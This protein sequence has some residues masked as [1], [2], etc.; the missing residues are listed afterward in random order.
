MAGEESKTSVADIA[1]ML[2]TPAGQADGSLTAEEENSPAEGTISDDT[3]ETDLTTDDAYDDTDAGADDAGDQEQDDGEVSDETTD[4]EEDAGADSEPAIIDIRDDD[5]IDVMIDGKLETKTIGELKKAISLS[6]A[7]EKRLHE[8]TEIR[9]TAMA[10]RTTALETLAAQERIVAAAFSSLE[11]TL[12]KAVIPAPDPKMKA[13]NPAAYL[14]HK[15]AYDED[16]A[17]IA[18]AKKAVQDKVTELATQRQTRLKEYGETAAQQIVAVIPEL[19]NPAKADQMLGKL[20]ATAKAYGYTDQEISG[21]LDPRMFHLV[22]DAMAYR[23]ITSRSKEHRVSDLSTQ[24]SKAPRKLRSGNTK[25]A[26]IVANKAKQ[27]QEAKAAAA[28]TGSVKDVAATLL[29]PAK[30]K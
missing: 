17:R 1:K 6:G 9:K 19:K 29:Q 7:T 8:A 10:E 27:Q 11:D 30:A 20:V 13:T 12:F 24:R 4:E 16:Q 23:E 25:A 28:K 18:T 21:A 15:E 22:R 26:S 2:L 14:R 5:L 3:E